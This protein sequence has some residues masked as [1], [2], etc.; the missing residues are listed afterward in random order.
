MQ[1]MLSQGWAITS[2]A[3]DA[4]LAQLISEGDAFIP[5]LAG[6]NSLEVLIYAGKPYAAAR[7][8]SQ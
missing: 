4:L 2:F 7:R 5:V 6:T 1:D 8:V 3:V